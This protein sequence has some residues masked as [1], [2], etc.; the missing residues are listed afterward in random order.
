MTKMK[1][2]QTIQGSNLLEFIREPAY[3]CETLKKY[4]S[5]SLSRYLAELSSEKPV[6]GGGS[7]SAYCACLGIGLAE[8]VAQIGI[9][10]AD[11]QAR[12]GLR[13]TIRILQKARKDVLQIVDLDPRVYQTVMKTYAEA[14][15]I[16]DEKKK[17]WL[18]DEALENSFRLQADLALLTAMAREAVRSMNGII[19]GSIKN[20]LRVSSAILEAAFHGAFATAEIN[21][22]YLR[23]P[24]KK[25]RAREALDELKKKFEGQNGSGS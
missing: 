9:K 4:T 6:P 24:E 12:P 5:L 3:T 25:N 1:E 18:I 11:V 2:N 22:V 13:R 17:E 8:M 23:N 20:D 7:V 19:K 15:K 21:Q 14:K 16:S 10:K